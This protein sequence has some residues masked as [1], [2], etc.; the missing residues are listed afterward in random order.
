MAPFGFGKKTLVCPECR[1]KGAVKTFASLKCPNRGCRHYDSATAWRPE[2]TAPAD[3]R[4]GAR[5]AGSFDPG[6]NTVVIRYRNYRG[7]DT[8]YIADRATIRLRREHLTARVAPTGKRIA[9]AKK[10]IR[11]LA[12]LPLPP[13][14]AEPRGVERQILCFHLRRGSTSPRF[15]ELKRKYPGFRL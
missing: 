15:E 1:S 8:E 7:D 6:P 5:H 10:F 13:A 14:S 2:P 12:E 9:L 11:N 4:P 3:A